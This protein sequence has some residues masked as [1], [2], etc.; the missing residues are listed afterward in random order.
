MTLKIDKIK[1]SYDKMVSDTSTKNSTLQC[2][3]TASFFIT[4]VLPRI[5]IYKENKTNYQKPALLFL[6]TVR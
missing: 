3:N 4:H 1:F 2:V 6:L 5:K